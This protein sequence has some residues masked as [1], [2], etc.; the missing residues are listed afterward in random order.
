MVETGILPQAGGQLDA[1]LLVRRDLHSGGV[2]HAADVAAL[3]QTFFFDLGGDLFKLVTGES[4]QAVVQPAGDNKGL[5]H[6]VAELGGEIQ[7]AF[8]VDGVVVLAYQHSRSP[9]S[10]VSTNLRHAF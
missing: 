6:G 8:G 3:D 5:T 2:E 10:S 1:A 9:L 4:G 7:A